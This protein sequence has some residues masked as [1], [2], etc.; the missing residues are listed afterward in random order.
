MVVVCG[1]IALLFSGLVIGGAEYL[2]FKKERSVS[3]LIMIFARDII[4]LNLVVLAVMKYLLKIPE[5]FNLK[6][7][8]PFYSLKYV[9]LALAVGVAYL[10]V[11]GIIEGKLT[12]SSDSRKVT[13]KVTIC[14]VISIVLFI[15]GV[16][17]FTGTIW[18]KATFGDITPDQFL[19]NLK[20]P[21]VGTS[22]DVYMTCIKG[23]VFETAVLT[24][25]FSC[26]VCSSKRLRFITDSYE[27]T[28]FDRSSRTILSVILSVAMLAGGATYGVV[29]FN[30]TA[31]YDAY[32]SDSSF[33]EDNYV[34]PRNTKMSFPEKKRNLIHIYLES[35]ENSYLSKDLGGY[36]QDN[37]MPELTELANEG[38]S[39]SHNVDTFGGPYQSTGSSWSVA[40]MVNMEMGL[41][42]KIPMDGNS[43]GNSGKFLPG[44]IAIGDILAAQGYEQSLLLGSDADFGGLTSLFD[45]HGEYTVLDHQEAQKR[46]YIPTDYNVW[47]GYE[48]DKLYSY[49][50]DELTRMA[51]T[52]KP[53]HFEM[54]T[55]DTHFPNG[56]QGPGVKDIHGNPYANVISYSTAETVKFVRWIQ[57][58]P[59]Y[60]N[61]TIVLTGDHTS[62]DQDFFRDFDPAYQ[63]TVFNLFLNSPVKP[64]GE[65]YN[66]LF[67]PFDFY[68]TILSSIDIQIEG[69]KLGLGT[70]LFSQEKTLMENVGKSA[71]DEELNKRSNFYNDEFVSERKDSKFDNENVTVR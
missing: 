50:K 38:V 24:A 4:V 51:E 44:A 48:D 54:E 20:S 26:F 31:V 13:A 63:R 58:Q 23:P 7:H 42:L 25:L 49:A 18:G 52:G 41:P 69:N 65:V 15:I 17:C 61:T 3:K 12:Y 34:E 64:Q 59:F 43:Y 10:F 27:K 14:R 2:L 47:W 70:N 32:V 1:V 29:K 66:R 36:G 9:V 22:S 40:G 55:A 35:V 19:I 30:L 45:N 68:P 21:I 57:E 60:E 46:G 5:V 67:A 53:F 6:F 71:I 11:R 16:A 37:L 33:V 39:F 28:L 56:Y 62:M 8:G